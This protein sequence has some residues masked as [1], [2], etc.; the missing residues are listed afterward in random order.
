MRKRLLLV[1]TCLALG[2]CGHADYADQAHRCVE[3]ME[4]DGQMY[5]I[6]DFGQSVTVQQLGPATPEQMAERRKLRLAARQNALTALI[7]HAVP[8]EGGWTTWWKDEGFN[9]PREPF[10]G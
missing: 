2:A 6:C 8:P 9:R 10:G 1:L 4:R 7:E 5:R 3:A